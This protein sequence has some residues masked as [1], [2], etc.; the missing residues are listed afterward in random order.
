M[1]A[2]R[3]CMLVRNDCRTDQ[4]VLKQAGSLARA[5]YD[6]TV[7]AINPYGPAQREERDGFRIV[8]VPVERSSLRLM[9][10]FNL[11]PRAIWRMARAARHVSADIYHAHDSD[12]IVP[13]WLAARGVRGAKLLYDAHEVG[14]VSLRQS[15]TFFRGAV[16]ALNWIWS[17]LNDRIVSRHAD[18][19]IAVNDMLADMQAA[20]YHIARPAVVMNCPP[21]LECGQKADAALATR[22]GVDPTTPIVICQGMFSLKRG[23][24]P[25]LANLVRSAALLRH[26]VIVLVGNV[27]SAPEFESLRQLASEPAYSGRVYILPAVPPAD[28]MAYTCGA[29]LGLIP[30]QL[31]ALFRYA[32]P[33]KLFEYLA[34]GLPVVTSDLPVVRRICEEY[35][36]GLL[37]DPGSPDSIADAINRLLGDSS[38]YTA[39]RQGALRAAQFYNWER[40]EQVLLGVY[41]RL[42]GA[43]AEANS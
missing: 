38:M 35:G 22:I 16:A 9:R 11:L 37:C 36:C 40:Q 41:R 26:G 1:A 31:S 18:A 15:F 2:A 7:V 6:L 21:R 10:G 23:D 39:M 19:V 28:L 5:G 4:R 29:Q 25:G 32:A 13:A 12:A 20:H 30:L 27:G 3:V 8:R 34:A 24:G 43:G 42:L 14:F 33:N 17:R